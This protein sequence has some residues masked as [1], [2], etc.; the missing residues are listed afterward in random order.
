VIVVGGICVI[1]DDQYSKLSPLFMGAEQCERL[2]S[3]GPHV[4]MC[5]L[6]HFVV[7]GTGT[8]TVNDTAYTV[9]PGQAFIIKPGDV[10]TYVADKDDPWYYIWASFDLDSDILDGIPYIVDNE[11]I[12]NIFADINDNF[13]FSSENQA[14]AISHI[15]KIYGN[16]VSLTRTNENNSYIREAVSIIKQQYM[17]DISVKSISDQLGL[18]RSYFCNLFKKHVGA[19]PVQFIINYRMQKALK[20]LNCQKYS[21]SVIA[22]SVGY[23]DLF[24][25]SRSFKKYYGVPPQRYKEIDPNKLSFTI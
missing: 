19:T 14:F 17:N 7:S 8:Y 16:L 25:F 22:T 3:F 2:H 9:Q 1:Q 10:T 4:R 6:I 5:W 24:S 13:D 15:W 12:R 11:E 18:D 23:S 21:V 20:L